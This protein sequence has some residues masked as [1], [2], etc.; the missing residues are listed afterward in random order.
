MAVSTD[1]QVSKTGTASGGQRDGDVHDLVAQRLQQ[2]RSVHNGVQA[3]LVH[4]H[5]GDALA[6]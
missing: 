5:V 6:R 4:S 3:G 2:P 1:Q